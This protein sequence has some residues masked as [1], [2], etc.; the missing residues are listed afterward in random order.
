MRL[1][2]FRAWDK[3][4]KRMSQPFGIAGEIGCMVR[5]P[6][7]NGKLDSILIEVVACEKERFTI[8]QYTSLKDRNNKEIYEYDILKH[9]DG[10]LGFVK[11]I[12]AEFLICF[13]VKDGNSQN[14]TMR[15][16]NVDLE[17]IEVIGNI[18]ENPELISKNKE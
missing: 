4:Y 14:I 16:S 5:F 7:E 10:Y 1:L 3:K 15:L 9:K 11:Y 6:E 17:N 2:K 13:P 18:F 12:N 8:M